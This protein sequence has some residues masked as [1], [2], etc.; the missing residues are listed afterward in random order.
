MEMHIIS[1]TGFHTYLITET[2]FMAHTPMSI[3]TELHDH[4][5]PVCFM[6]EAGDVVKTTY[7]EVKAAWQVWR[8]S[9]AGEH[10][11]LGIIS[12]LTLSQHPNTIFPPSYGVP[13]SGI[14][15]SPA[16]LFCY[17]QVINASST[18]IITISVIKP[19][20]HPRS[21]KFEK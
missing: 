7:P 11:S 12:P 8:P 10:Q 17:H 3:T 16:I 1:L 2:L 6:M 13:I 21:Y 20:F 4:I 5:T 19:S 15:S 18:R 9:K 14:C